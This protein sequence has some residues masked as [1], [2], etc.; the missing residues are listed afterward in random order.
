MLAYDD[1]RNFFRMMVNSAC[2]VK[3][4]DA[5]QG[6]TMIAVCRDISATGM[7]IELNAKKINVG[8]LLEII[9]DSQN[10]ELQSLVAK[11]KVVRCDEIGEQSC[12]V[13]VEISEMS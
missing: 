6:Q 11:C 1:K 3:L 7:S 5:P 9:I 12:L 10:D 13:G 4:I 2:Q 8:T